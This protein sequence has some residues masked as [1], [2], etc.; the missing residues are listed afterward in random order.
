MNGTRV[1]TVAVTVSII[2]ITQTQ[3][4]SSTIRWSVRMAS[5]VTTIT[6]QTVVG[7]PVAAVEHPVTTMAL[8]AMDTV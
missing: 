1:S 5:T 3:G 8:L 2:T 4:R 7:L 6:T